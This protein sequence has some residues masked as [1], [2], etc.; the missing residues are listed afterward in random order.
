VVDFSSNVS[1]K[2]DGQKRQADKQAVRQLGHNRQKINLKKTIGQNINTHCT[3]YVS[4]KRM[5]KESSCG[6]LKGLPHEMDLAF[7][8][9]Y[10]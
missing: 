8:D 4:I 6:D 10:G 2:E 9:I 5:V 1:L 3:A 7:D